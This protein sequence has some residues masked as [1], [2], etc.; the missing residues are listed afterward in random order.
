MDKV[1]RADTYIYMEGVYDMMAKLEQ[2][3]QKNS[4]VFTPATTV[5]LSMVSE[6]TSAC[7]TKVNLLN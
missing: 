4:S 3:L 5:P 6:N 2:L 7:E 1:N